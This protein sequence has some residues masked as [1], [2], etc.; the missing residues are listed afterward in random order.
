MLVFPEWPDRLDYLVFLDILYRLEK[1][2][3]QDIMSI[4][5]TVP[6]YNGEDKA[7]VCKEEIG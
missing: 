7:Y 5:I 1:L 3:I 6:R 2:A 4:K